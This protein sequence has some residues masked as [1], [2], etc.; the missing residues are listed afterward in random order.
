[1]GRRD[2]EFNR[3]NSYFCPED[4]SRPGKPCGVLLSDEIE[5]YVQQFR[6]ID[7]FDRKNLKPAA[8]ELTVGDQYSLG[9]KP[10]WLKEG[11]KITIPPFQVAIIKIAETI[12][13][14]RF[15]IARWNIRVKWAYQGLLWVGG[16]QVDP[17]WIGPLCCPIYNLSS[18]EVKIPR[19]EP[20]AV[21]DFVT[22]T[23]FLKGKSR[24]YEN[25]P[26][27]RLLFEDYNAD[28]QSALFTE[29]GQRIGAVESAVEK[30]IHGVESFVKKSSAVAIT[31]LTILFAVLAMFVSPSERAIPWW[32]VVSTVF[33]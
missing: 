14:P 13:L 18:Q 25:R 2:D 15:L 3:L 17:G 27:K 8:Y 33:S 7:P 20:I 31:I 23:P 21:M 32:L 19:G 1:M 22:T 9:G 28:L 26:P 30:K 5:H 6:M 10:C 12:N 16:P 4:D 11:E 29:A 24:E